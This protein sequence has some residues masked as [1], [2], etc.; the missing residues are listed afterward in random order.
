MF[1]SKVVARAINYFDS[2][3]LFDSGEGSGGRE[4]GGEGGGGR[5]GGEG[6][7]VG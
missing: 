3:Q 6:G 1:V 5:G 2:L 4:G 7:G